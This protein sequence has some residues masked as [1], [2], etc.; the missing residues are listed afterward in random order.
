MFVADKNGVIFDYKETE[1]YELLFVLELLEK[2]WIEPVPYLRDGITKYDLGKNL[3]PEAYMKA[4]KKAR[5]KKAQT[6]TEEEF[7]VKMAEFEELSDISQE[8]VFAK[9]KESFRNRKKP[10]QSFEDFFEKTAFGRFLK[11]EFDRVVEETKEIPKR[12]VRSFASYAKKIL[13]PM[14]N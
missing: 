3:F 1:E 4:L 14:S 7:K 9:I 11:G 12:K 13:F 8:D 6:S 10:E 2:Y 5:Q